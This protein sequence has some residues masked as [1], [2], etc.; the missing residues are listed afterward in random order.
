ML[1]SQR[2]S[3]L[4]ELATKMGLEIIEAPLD[5]L[6]EAIRTKSANPAVGKALQRSGLLAINQDSE[7]VAFIHLTFQEFYLACSLRSAGL[8]LVLERYWT[9]VRYE[10]SLG[11]L[12]SLLASERR[13]KEIADG[14]KWLVDRGRQIHQAN[15]KQLWDTAAQSVTASLAHD[16][17]SWN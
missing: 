6:D 5:L 9:D 13:Y 11:L 14:L 3:V 15:P 16:A 17:A 4:I 8:R 12:I 7:T 1:R 10:E 2:D